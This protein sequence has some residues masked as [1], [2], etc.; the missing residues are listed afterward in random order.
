MRGVMNKQIIA[1]PPSPLIYASVNWISFGSSNGLPP[2]R[3]QAIIW[4]YV[5]LFSILL[6]GTI[7]SEI[8]LE[9]MLYSLKKVH[10]KLPSAKMAA[11]F[12]NGNELN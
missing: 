12:S 3:R 7:F 1:P 10:L 11:V 8:R 5:G 2:L 4:T 6:A 9:I